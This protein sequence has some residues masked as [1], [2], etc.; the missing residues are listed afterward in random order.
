[1]N[2]VRLL[3]KVEEAARKRGNYEAWRAS[4]E[5]ADKAAHEKREEA[6]VARLAELGVVVVRHAA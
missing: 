2:W 6:R 1:M 4:R 3:S 5:R